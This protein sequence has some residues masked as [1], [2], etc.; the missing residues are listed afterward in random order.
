[1]KTRYSDR[2]AISYWGKTGYIWGGSKIEGD[3]FKE[4]D[5]VHVKV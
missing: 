1:M 3:G 4:G 2:K 5:V